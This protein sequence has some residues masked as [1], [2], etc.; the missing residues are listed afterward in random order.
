[1]ETHNTAKLNFRCAICGGS[2][3]HVSLTIREPDRFEKASGVTLS[4]YERSWVS[5]QSCFVVQNET[6]QESLEKLQ[7]ISSSY[8]QIDLGG[9]E[10]LKEK[11]Q[12]VMNMDLRESDNAV[13][14]ER[15]LDFFANSQKDTPIRAVDIGA[16]TGV[17][18]AKLVERTKQ[19]EISCRVVA[20]EPDPIA[21]RHLREISGIEVFPDVFENYPQKTSFNL[22]TINKVLEHFRSPL[23]ILKKAQDLLSP[24]TGILYVEVPDASTMHMRSSSDNI[25]GPLHHHLYTPHS[26]VGVLERAGWFSLKCERVFDPSGKITVYAFACKEAA[27][28]SWDKRGKLK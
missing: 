14:V 6:P 17:F 4:P 27:W 8:Y 2:N 9:Y 15:V 18:A 19:R 28:K 16:G 23:E 21:V 13:R 25:L 3:G 24:E 11:F 20:V 5:C 1:M 7:L 26:L 12:K 10:Q 22:C